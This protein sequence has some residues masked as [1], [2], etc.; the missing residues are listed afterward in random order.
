[1][2]FEIEFLNEVVEQ[3]T[4]SLPSD[5]LADLLHVMELIQEH[6]IGVGRHYTKPMTG[7]KGLFEIRAKAASGIGRALYC[8]AVGKKI[9]IL[10]S[11]VKKTEKT[12]L[13][14]IRIALERMKEVRD[15]QS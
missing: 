4:L 15:V 8:Y 6:G 5:I 10:H 9:I 13:K 14:E 3:E 7:H 2:K 12:P 1:M 11:F